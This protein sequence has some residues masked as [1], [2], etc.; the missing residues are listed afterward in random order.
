MDDVF[1]IDSWIMS[2]HVLG[3]GVQNAFQ[4]ILHKAKVLNVDICGQYLPSSKNSLVSDLY[5]SLGFEIE[6]VLRLL[7]STVSI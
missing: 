1:F 4:L 5:P 2:C 3:R 6:E 7:F